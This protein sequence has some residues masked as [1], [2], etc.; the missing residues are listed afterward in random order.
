MFIDRRAHLVKFLKKYFKSNNEMIEIKNKM[1]LRI[2]IA[3]NDG[4]F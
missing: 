3:W 2:K 1:M 4:W